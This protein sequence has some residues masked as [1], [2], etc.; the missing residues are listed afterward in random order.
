MMIKRQLGKTDMYVSPIGLGCMGFSHAYGL[1][2]DKERA[3]QTIKQAYKMG[4]NFF[5]TA[6]CYTGENTDGTISYNEELV[7]EALKE[8]REQVV[9]ATKFGV[10][11]KGDHLELDSSPEKIYASIEGSLKKLQTDYIDLYYQHRIDPKVEPEVVAGVMKELIAAGKIKAWG[12]SETTEEYLRRA[13]AVCPVTAIQNRYSMMARWYEDLFVVCKEL[14]IT[15][16]AFSPMA[17]GLLSGKFT[18][19]STFEKGDFRNNMPQYQ[20]EGYEKAKKLLNLLKVLSEKKNCTMA[21][22][23]IAWMLRKKD[24]IV[25]IPGS[26]KLERL[27]ENF[28]AGEIEVTID[29]IKEIDALLD[30]IDFDVFGGH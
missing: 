18:P 9:I 8:V 10:E 21:Q 24:F 25:P 2:E 26:R 19:D 17:N 14:G 4:Y 30:T 13:H 27:E 23:S 3:I 5:D 15:Y 20:K 16:V 7:G 1:A 6:E 28:R 22:L 11:H 29:E 12:I